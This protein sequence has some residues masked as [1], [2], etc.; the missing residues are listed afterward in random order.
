[1]GEPSRPGY[2]LGTSTETSWS[3]MGVSGLPEPA[4][5]DQGLAR[6][7]HCRGDGYAR[8]GRDSLG[9]NGGDGIDGDSPQFSV[10]SVDS[11]DS[12]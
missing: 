6:C 5:F 7:G 9:G 8:F 4:D 11:V 1:M 12:V 10:D 3:E 2:R